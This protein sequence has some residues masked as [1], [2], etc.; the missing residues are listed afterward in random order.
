MW[1]GAHPPRAR[2]GERPGIFLRLALLHSYLALIL[3]NVLSATG[4]LGETNAKLSAQFQTPLTPSGWAFAIWGLI[5]ALQGLGVVYQV[6]NRGYSE[7]GW[8]TDVVIKIGWCWQLGW[9]FQDLWQF[10]FAQQ[11]V[12]GMWLAAACL[13]GAL[14]AFLTALNRLNGTTQELR[15]RGYAA[16]PAVAYICFKLPTAINAAWLSVA[17]SLGLLI[18]PVSY[19]VAAGK[20]V[21]PAAVLAVAV[22]AGGVW[23]LVRH[24]DVAYGLTLIWALAAVA[25]NTSGNVPTA[26]KVVG[27]VCLVVLV[28]FVASALVRTKREL[29]AG[30]GT[31]AASGPDGELLYDNGTHTGPYG[32]HNGPY[33]SPDTSYNG[34]H[35]NDSYK[36]CGDQRVLLSDADAPA[37][38]QHSGG[39]TF[40]PGYPQQQQ[41]HHHHN[42]HTTTTVT[43]GEAVLAAPGAGGAAPQG[44]FTYP[45]QHHRPHHHQQQHTAATIM[46]G[47]GGAPGMA[48]PGRVGAPGEGGAPGMAAGAPFVLAAPSEGRVPQLAAPSATDGAKGGAMRKAPSSS[49]LG[50]PL[51]AFTPPLA[52]SAAEAFGWSS[53]AVGLVRAERGLLGPLGEA[54]A[55]ASVVD[56]RVGSGGGGDGPAPVLAGW[57]V[58]GGGPKLLADP[59]AAAGAF[60]T[61]VCLV[62]Q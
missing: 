31:A 15:A 35:T 23:R 58:D 62:L 33:E 60:T 42:S 17:A 9:L 22:T 3:V 45:Q 11:S 40:P 2:S 39:F 13:L 59:Q 47:G 18:A 34:I 27:I 54:G 57:D 8:K 20:L 56:L 16:M 5:F 19:G 50:T 26:V 61:D 12:V 21:A 48:A 14:T 10:A 41:H 6:L 4:A 29:S 55:G 7:G 36:L 32:T 52:A 1:S 49:G 46:A 30:A 28:L 51:D 44:F 38:F 37:G 25:T 53:T 24:L 43:F